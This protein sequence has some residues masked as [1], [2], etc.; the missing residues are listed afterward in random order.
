M[1]LK[2]VSEKIVGYGDGVLIVPSGIETSFITVA[3]SAFEV[4]IVPSG[5]E[6]STDPI[7]DGHTYV[8]IVPSGI[9]TLHPLL[10]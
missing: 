9:E 3:A 5:I 6:T 7:G 10:R 8:L 4:L 2:Q 1:E